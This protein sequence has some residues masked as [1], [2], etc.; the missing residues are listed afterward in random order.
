M[1]VARRSRIPGV[2]AALP[3]ATA[4]AAGCTTPQTGTVSSH[5]CPGDA[6]FTTL[7]DMED[8]DG[9]LC[10]DWGS[11]SLSVGAGITSTVP[12]AIDGSL[13]RTEPT[14]GTLG[15][16]SAFPSTR[17]IHL[18]ASGFAAGS[19]PAHWATL[20]AV[21]SPPGPFPLSDYTGLRFQA[22]ASVVSQMRV[23]V[24]T[25]TT[26][27]LAA[28]DSFGRTIS[29]QTTGTQMVV[30]FATTTQEGYGT[31]VVQDFADATL[32]S[33]DFKL[34]AQFLD[35]TRDINPDTLDIWIDDVQLIR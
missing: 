16:V 14:D 11:W 25:S 34:A 30:P 2:L 31:G 4:L 27:D 5:W 26:R 12:L 8:G 23:N 7:D 9:K 17:A 22:K 29:V 21:F 1:V 6:T 28:G 15:T 20:S 24:A 3:L 33:F 13:Q 10:Q 35:D 18:T 32:L 19:D